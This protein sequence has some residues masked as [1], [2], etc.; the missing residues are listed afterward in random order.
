MGINL[1]NKYV[2]LV[3]T[4]QRAGEISLKEIQSKWLD[5]D[6]SEGVELS[7][8]TFHKWRIATEELFG[9][10][11]DCRRTGGYNYYIANAEVL[12]EGDIRSWL[13]STTSLQQ[14][15]SHSISLSERIL[16]EYIP[17]S[18]SYLSDIIKAMKTSHCIEV[19][20]Q[21]YTSATP[22]TSILEP[23]ALKV[24]KQRWYLL[25]K[26]TDMPYLLL[27]SLDRMQGVT[28][29]EQKYQLSPEFD[30][31]EFFED[32][33]G[34]IIDATVEAERIELRVTA[35]QACYLKSL[36]LHHSQ[37]LLRED[38][39]YSVFEL[40]LKPTYD[41]LQALL[42]YGSELEVIAPVSLRKQM[43]EEVAAMMNRYR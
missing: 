19:T 15:L 7:Q 33:Y 37:R 2:W 31:E 35:A 22:R 10:C 20:Y 5:S 40:Y 3:E 6:L 23:Y 26:A 43:Q 39:E 24:F 30:A 9:I 14:Q 21:R 12:H 29:V 13:L 1:M 32:C 38:E 17:S 36:P 27:Y 28:L 18:Q 25:A 34:T 42:S 8:R 41:F 4:I 11:I 16:L